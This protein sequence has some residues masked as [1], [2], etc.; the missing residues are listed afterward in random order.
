MTQESRKGY[1]REQ[2]GSRKEPID[3]EELSDEEKFQKAG[4][5]LLKRERQ[6]MTRLQMAESHQYSTKH[7]MAG[8]HSR[9]CQKAGRPAQTETPR[10]GS[11]G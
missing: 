1:W 9:E 3:E 8:S 2:S 4:E 7:Q 11:S 10:K 6:K 5:T